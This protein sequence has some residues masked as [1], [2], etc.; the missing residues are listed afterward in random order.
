M[1]HTF[2]FL[3]GALLVC[4]SLACASAQAGNASAVTAPA[5]AANAGAGGSQQVRIG[6]NGIDIDNGSKHVRIG[7]SGISITNGSRSVQVTAPV[8][9]VHVQVPP[10]HVQV[11]SGQTGTCSSNGNEVVAIGHDATLPAGHNACDVVAIFGNATVHGNVSD[12]V[13]TV[14]GS[15]HVDGDVGNSVVSVLG[16]THIDGPVGQGAVAVLGNMHLGPHAIVGG[17]LVNILGSYTRAP[18]AVVQGGTVNLMSGF[19]HALPYFQSWSDHCLIFGRL[20]A[21]RLDI[22][23]AWAVALALLAFYLLLAALFHDGLQRCVLTLERHPGPS[24]LSALAMVLLTPILMLAL[25][26]TVVGIAV[27]PLFWF[28][29]FCAGIFGRVV[30]LGWLGGRLLRATGAGAAPAVTHV[31]VGG[32]VVL[33]LYMVPVLGFIVWALVGLLGFGALSYTV[34]LT[35]R[36]ARSGNAGPRPGAGPQ[37]GPGP[38]A[39]AFA[40]TASSGVD[41]SASQTRADSGA[42]DGSA[43]ADGPTTNGPAAAPAPDLTTLPRA[44]FWLRMAALLIDIVLV[45]FALSM[46][47][48]HG[49]DG[50]LLVLAGYGAVM[51]RLN[52]TTV[53][54]VICNLKVVRLD[55]QPIGWNT[56]ILRALGCFLSLVAAGLGFFW[57]AFDRE[58]QAWHDKIAGTVVVLVPKARGLV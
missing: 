50:M 42:A 35:A 44:G 21:P 36:S 22:G 19:A 18:T 54:G 39:G 25:V 24:I 38:Q 20:L 12:S 30:T 43:T 47:G 48:H 40:G 49:S 32:I 55:G 29:L 31:L 4:L 8:P 6:N 23:W 41:S 14:F 45:G 2:R 13:V 56:A 53:G 26:M 58:H 51:W 17:G 34:L 37:A 5:V 52:G 28:A 11:G 10:I 27:V 46:I 16:N 57:I 1:N 3:P 7:N 15:S 33:L 9:A